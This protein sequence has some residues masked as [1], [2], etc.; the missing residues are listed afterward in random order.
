MKRFFAFVF[1]LS[2]LASSS[3]AQEVKMSPTVKGSPGTWII[4][5]PLSVDGGK[6][7]WRLDPGLEE[8]RL[9]LL[10]P[11]EFIAQ[12]KGKVVTSQKAG[13]YKVEAWNAKGDVAS[14]IAVCVVVVGGGAAPD[15]PTPPLDA[16]TKRIV[17]AW[18]AEPESDR[19][20]VGVYRALFAQF[21]KEIYAKDAAVY[22]ASPYS[23]MTVGYLRKVMTDGRKLAIKDS[24]RGVAAV[25]GADMDAA[26]PTKDSVEID[27]VLRARFSAAFTKYAKALEACR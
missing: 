12:M 27:D 20:K 9:D 10:L 8:V 6:V 7:K 3:A 25:I 19:A 11:P 2:L 18:Q 21:A 16:F 24:L 23:Y 26:L 15:P 1:F 5:A 4:V 13:T 14:D 22:G 17:E